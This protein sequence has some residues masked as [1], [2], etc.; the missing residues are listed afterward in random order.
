MEQKVSSLEGTVV[1]EQPGVEVASDTST[2]VGHWLLLQ[3][4]HGGGRGMS[5]V[6]PNM[7]RFSA[8]GRQLFVGTYG[9]IMPARAGTLR[10][11]I[12]M[13]PCPLKFITN[14]SPPK[15]NDFIPPTLP[16]WYCSESSKATT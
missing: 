14:P 4:A 5:I 16:I 15:M 10:V 8:N 12:H 3:P 7:W 1:V 13:D 6:T 9:M 11:W 2:V